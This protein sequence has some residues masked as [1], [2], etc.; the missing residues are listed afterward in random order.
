MK[1]ASGLEIKTTIRPGKGGESHN[2][3]SGWHLVG[4]FSL[5]K[6]SGQVQFMHIM[7]A[8]LIGQG[9]PNADWKYVGSKVNAVTGSQRTETYT[10][11]PAGTAKLRHGTVYLDT[12]AIDISRWRTDTAVKAPPYSPF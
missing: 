2:G 3:H 8:D 7:F 4:C 9:K 5:N 12:A 1:G 11:T 6:E 10:T